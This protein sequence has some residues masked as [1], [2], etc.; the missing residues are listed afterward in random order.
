[1]EYC[2]SSKKKKK[3]KRRGLG[4]LPLSHWMVWTLKSS[5]LHG[6]RSWSKNL[7]YMSDLKISLGPEIVKDASI[8]SSLEYHKNVFVK[9]SVLVPYPLGIKILGMYKYLGILCTVECDSRKKLSQWIIISS[10]SGTCR[11][12]PSR[13][14]KYL[15]AAILKETSYFNNNS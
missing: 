13:P 11:E 14:A 8:N 9:Q 6:V 2:R 3:K 4:F 5:S 12:C 1:M 10:C 7:L 15:G